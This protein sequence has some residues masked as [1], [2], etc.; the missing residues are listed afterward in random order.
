MRTLMGIIW[1]VGWIAKLVGVNT[2]AILAIHHSY[3]A[4]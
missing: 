3:Q 2:Y 4:K 1:G